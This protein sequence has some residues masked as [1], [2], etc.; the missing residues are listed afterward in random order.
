MRADWPVAVC[1]YYFGDTLI[2]SSLVAGFYPP[3][4]GTAYINGVDISTDI[5][6]ARQGMGLCPQHDVLF[7]LL[8]VEQHLAFF[9][10]VSQRAF[11]N[12]MFLFVCST[13]KEAEEKTKKTKKEYFPAFLSTSARQG[14]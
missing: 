5:D 3:T 14:A 11:A 12:G 10:Q 7:D 13:V 6:R 1:H 8:T 9:A 2:T 4:S